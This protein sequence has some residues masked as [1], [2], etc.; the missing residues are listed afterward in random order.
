MLRKLIALAEDPALACLPGHPPGA[1]LLEVHRFQ[2]LLEQRLLAEQ[3]RGKYGGRVRGRDVPIGSELFVH[4]R[5]VDRA[6][7]GALI[8]RI[9]PN[10]SAAC[11]VRTG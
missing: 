9:A 5:V 6:G 10:M 4:R 8:R 2:Q 3:L 11:R 7:D 1:L